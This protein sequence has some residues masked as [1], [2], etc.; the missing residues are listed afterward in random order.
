MGTATATA[1][2]RAR[3]IQRA[4]DRKVRGTPDLSWLVTQRLP[5]SEAP[6]GYEMYAGR[7]DNVLKVVLEV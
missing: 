4:G 6:K 2:A 3:P 1:E 7:D 5:L